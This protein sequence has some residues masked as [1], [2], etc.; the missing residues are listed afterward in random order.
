MTSIF[1]PLS[2]E[3]AENLLE[4]GISPFCH[5]REEQERR[6][7]GALRLKERLS[8]VP[9]YAERAKRYRERGNEM[10]YWENMYASS[11]NL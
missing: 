10:L 5:L 1:D 9:F 8:S 6:M 7:Q 11:I 4:M 3:E 2:I